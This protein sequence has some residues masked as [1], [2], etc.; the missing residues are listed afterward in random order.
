MEIIKI[1]PPFLYSIKYDE[2][3]DNEYDRLFNQW[4]DVNYVVSFMNEHKSMLSND[5]WVDVREPEDA[6]RQVLEEAEDLEE[7]IDELC[8]NTDLGE[9]TRFGQSL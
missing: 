5:V 8:K 6:A 4:N 1:Y 3:D 7:L 9:N 2:T